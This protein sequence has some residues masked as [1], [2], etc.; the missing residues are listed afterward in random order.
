MELVGFNPK[1]YAEL[2]LITK[3]ELFETF[4]DQ[5]GKEAD[6]RIGG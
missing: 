5:T 1:V 4:E 2:G 3:V 6:D